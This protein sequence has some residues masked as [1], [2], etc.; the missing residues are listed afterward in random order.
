MATA[1]FGG[2][3]VSALV[4]DVGHSYTKAGYAGDDTPAAYIPSVLGHL[5]SSDSTNGAAAADGSTPM[6]V[7]QPNGDNNNGRAAN[8]GAGRRKRPGQWFAGEQRAL[9]WRAGMELRRP[10]VDGNVADWDAFE[11]LLDHTF[12]SHLRTDP[13]EHPLLMV[14]PAWNPKASRER[15]TEIAFEQFDFPAFFLAKAP[16]LSAFA[17]GRGSSL[18]IECGGGST[19]VSPVHE[20]YVLQKAATS[21]HIAGE[22]VSHQAHLTFDFNRIDIAPRYLIKGKRPVPLAMPASVDLRTERLAGTS[23]GYHDYAML[24]EFDDFKH[25]TMVCPTSL[26]NETQPASPAPPETRAHEFTC[27]YHNQFTTERYRLAEALFQ[28]AKYAIRAEFIPPRAPPADGS[29]PT[30]LHVPSGTVFPGPVSANPILSI[31]DLIRKAMAAVDA[32]VRP[33]LLAN[34]VLAGGTATQVPG[35]SERIVHELHQMYPG[36]KIKVVSGNTLPE[37]KFSA[38][39]GGSVLASLGTFHQMWISKKEYEEHGKSIVERK[40]M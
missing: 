6:D 2:D 22:F 25:S 19:S 3:E 1:T 32:D 10:I 4:L 34:V 36:A 11:E 16:V 26:L 27:G 28:P 21:Q 17:A 7:D 29:P 14:E 18:V 37:R 9:S 20:G 31:P 23:Q 39:L 13:T 24:R 40:C 8:N 15:M 35:F 12:L 30:V 33:S 38:W 5:P